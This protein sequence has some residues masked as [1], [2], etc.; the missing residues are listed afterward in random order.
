MAPA[1]STS[2]PVGLAKAV[3]LREFPHACES[4]SKSNPLSRVH[5]LRDEFRIYDQPHTTRCLGWSNLSFDAAWE[6]AADKLGEVV[7]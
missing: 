2:S 3:V 5:G 6:D 7:R 1:N 4:F